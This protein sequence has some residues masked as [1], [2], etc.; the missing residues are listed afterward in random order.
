M[1]VR[2]LADQVR[3]YMLEMRHEFHRHPELSGQEFETSRRICEELDRMGVEY[4]H[5]GDTTGILATMKGGRPGK[6]LLMREDMD[7]LKV[8]EEACVDFKSEVPGVM[9][10][11][12]HDA[13]SAILLATIKALAPVRDELSGTLKFLFQPAEEIGKGGVWMMANHVMD[14]VDGAYGMHLWAGL[15]VGKISVD[16]GPRMSSCGF[17]DIYVKGKA[18]HGAMPQDGIDAGVATAAIMMNMQTLASREVSPLDN[19]VVTMGYMQAGTQGN[20]I[21]G[22]GHLSGTTRTYQ[23]GVR[24]RF[25]ERIR[26][27]AETTAET[28]RATARVEYRDEVAPVIN[29]PVC[30]ARAARA[31]TKLFGEE[32]LQTF[33]P[34]TGAEDMSAYIDAAPLKGMMAFVG[35]GNPAIGADQ[36]HHNSK[37]MIDEEGMYH[38]LLLGMQ[39]AMDW[40]EEYQG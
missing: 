27:I 12:G 25:E 19:V 6:T 9:H 2:Q 17:F 8:T 37:F 24:S 10:A 4:I 11:C 16:E 32:A 14:G 28:F 15:P 36:P 40:M 30:S 35:V 39:Y 3:E 13:H 22:E 5:V 1:D 38:A 23:A 21:A 7:A 26:R 33:P 20:I 34:M 31:V 18:A 29:D